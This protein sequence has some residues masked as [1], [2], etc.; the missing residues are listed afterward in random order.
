MR[1]KNLLNPIQFPFRVEEFIRARTPRKILDLRNQI[2]NNPNFLDSFLNNLRIKSK[3]SEDLLSLLLLSWYI[4]E[5]IGILLRLEIM[6]KEK[7]FNEKDKI[8][9][10]IFL[11]S[12]KDS[13]DLLFLT[14]RWHSRDLFGNFLVRGL[15]EL[16]NLQFKRRNSKILQKKIRKRGYQDHGSRRPDFKWLPSSDYSFTEKQNQK[17]LAEI[18]FH[19]KYL[20]ILKILRTFSRSKE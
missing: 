1:D 11:T 9:F 20:R 6:E 2:L 7:F 3:K 4:P 14:Q 8:F 19:S 15:K 13:L 16:E 12:K 17:E 10:K 18:K 5:E